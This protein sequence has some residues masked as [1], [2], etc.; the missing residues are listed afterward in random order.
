MQTERKYN[1]RYSFVF[2]WKGKI[3]LTRRGDQ[4]LNNKS[5]PNDRSSDS[6]SHVVSSYEYNRIIRSFKL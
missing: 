6:V 2:R 3:S 1:T 4:V 5:K